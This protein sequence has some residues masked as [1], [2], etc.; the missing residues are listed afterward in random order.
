MVGRK[1]VGEQKWIKLKMM[2]CRWSQRQGATVPGSH[3]G[4]PLLYL[5]DDQGTEY[6]HTGRTAASGSSPCPPKLL[7]V[8]KDNLQPGPR[9]GVHQVSLSRQTPGVMRVEHATS[10]DPG[11]HQMAQ[12]GGYMYLETYM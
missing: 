12:N 3:P 1:R 2:A 10:S 6:M 8:V 9:N 4:A 11:I 5:H 7:P